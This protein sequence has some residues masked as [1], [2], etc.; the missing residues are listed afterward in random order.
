MSYGPPDAAQ[1]VTGSA[2]DFALLVTRRLHR[3]DAD[4]VAVGADADAWL[5]G[6]QAVAGPPGS[7]RPP[8]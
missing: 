3:N 6:A 8:R 7:G 1:S 5:D 4:L 2:Y